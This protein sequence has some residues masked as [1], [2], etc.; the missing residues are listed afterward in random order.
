MRTGDAL[1]QML[2]VAALLGATLAGGPVLS[3]PAAA[4]PPSCPRPDT[5]RMRPLDSWKP[6]ISAY[7][8]RHYG[9]NT[10]ELEPQVIVLHYTVSQGF[11]WNLVN[12]PD[13]AGETPGLAVHYVVDGA[14]LWQLLPDNVR[15]RG[16]F[17]INHRAINIEMVAMHAADLQTR[18]KTLDTTVAL[19]RCL[20]QTHA[21]PLNK[22]YSHEDVSKMNPTLTPEVKDLLHPQPYGKQD[23]GLANMRYIL[24][25]LAPAPASAP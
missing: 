9:E 8:Q 25:R 11:P 19:V 4:A 17:G 21:I 2:G 14:Q 24:E 20:M 13:F 5:S 22:I 16:A 12:T 6:Q 15:S 23:P 7:S 18:R 10:W 3:R 1:R